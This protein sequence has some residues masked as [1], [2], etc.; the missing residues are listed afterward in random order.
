VFGT[1]CYA[2]DS[3]NLAW[4]WSLSVG[5]VEGALWTADIVVKSRMVNQRLIPSNPLGVKSVGEAATIGSPPA[6]VGAVVDALSPL[7][8]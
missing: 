4:K 6:V 3:S 7:G 2:T 8:V 5:D 1:P